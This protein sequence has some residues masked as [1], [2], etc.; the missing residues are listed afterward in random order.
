M[1]APGL[2][3]AATADPDPPESAGETPDGAPAHLPGS[4]APSPESPAYRLQDFDTLATVGEFGRGDRP[5][6]TLDAVGTLASD[7][8]EVLPRTAPPGRA[9]PG[10][11]CPG[12]G[13]SLCPGSQRCPQSDSESPRAESLPTCWHPASRRQTHLM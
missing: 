8:G 3:K 12:A 6:G 10:P 9:L 11:A 2:T 1:E 4:E 13:L 5:A 7:K